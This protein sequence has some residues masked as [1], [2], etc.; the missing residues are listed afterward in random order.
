M[1][2]TNKLNLPGPIFD[3]ISRDEYSRGNADISVTQLIDSPR[4]RMMYKI[5]DDKMEI[6]A[7][8]LLAS[9]L[10]R[11]FHKA[12]E[13]AT[14]TGLAENRFF[15][16]VY[17][18]TLSGGIDH[19]EN[20][21]ITDYKTAN[22]FKVVYS[23]HGTVEE[24]ESQLN[25]Y[26]YLLRV[27]G[28]EVKELKIF[29]LF[30]DWNRRDF[31][32]KKEKGNLW[33]PWKRSGYPDNDWAHINIPLWPESVVRLYIEERIK[34]HQEAEKNLPECEPEETWRGKRCLSYCQAADWCEQFKKNRNKT[35][36]VRKGIL[37]EEE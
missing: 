33:A 23:H 12:I 28:H 30:K 17:G 16:K 1:K 7:S 26:A 20:G 8:K 22:V 15:A 32:S 18:W 14:K 13:V 21:I 24:W 36:L 34:A 29:V 4:V 25:V 27:N 9:T 5:H 19:F 31:S 6:E 37:E 3:L 11:A 35:F 2:I 10:G